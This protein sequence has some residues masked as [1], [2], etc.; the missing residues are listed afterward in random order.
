MAETL[1]TDELIDG[2]RLALVSGVGP[3]HRQDLLATVWLAG[4]GARGG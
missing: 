1:Y 4:G 3:R 2:V